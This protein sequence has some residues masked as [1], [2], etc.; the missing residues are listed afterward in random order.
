MV[1]AAM[2]AREDA[3][4]EATESSP[5]R[6]SVAKAVLDRLVTIAHTFARW[7]G[8]LHVRSGSAEWMIESKPCDLLVP[9]ELLA[10]G[11]RLPPNLSLAK[12]RTAPL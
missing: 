2:L 12:T 9:Y 11:F 3:T 6:A 7:C 5:I 1:L 8:L 10:L 4:G